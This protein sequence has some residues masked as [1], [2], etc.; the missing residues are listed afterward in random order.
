MLACLAEWPIT[1]FSCK[2]RQN[3]HCNLG[4]YHHCSIIL[5]LQHNDFVCRSRLTSSR[6][7]D[8]TGNPSCKALDSD[9]RQVLSCKAAVTIEHCAVCIYAMAEMGQSFGGRS[10]L[11]E[12][13]KKFEDLNILQPQKYNCLKVERTWD[14]PLRR[15]GSPSFII[16]KSRMEQWMV[17][18]E[19]YC[20][21]SIIRLIGAFKPHL[22]DSH[23]AP[24]TK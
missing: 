14:E 18:A 9:C 24:V 19:E 22:D 15:A 12:A 6:L 23:A 4:S 20:P 21:L 11:I 17:S 8:C 10:M 16:N 1:R 5:L 2:V 3:Q 7:T 13:A